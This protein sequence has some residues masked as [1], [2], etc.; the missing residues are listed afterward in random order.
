MIDCMTG[1]IDARHA[2]SVVGS[3][4]SGGRGQPATDNRQ[5]V[6]PET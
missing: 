4:L 2:L 6:N 5:L 3:Q 1:V